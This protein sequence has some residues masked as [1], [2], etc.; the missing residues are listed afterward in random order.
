MANLLAITKNKFFNLVLNAL[1]TLSSI[2]HAYP[3]YILYLLFFTPCIL[4]ILSFLSPLFITTSLLIISLFTAISPGFVKDTLFGTHSSNVKAN[5]LLSAYDAVSKI[6][7]H[8][9][10]DEEEDFHSLEALEMYKIVFNTSIIDERGNHVDVS[11][12]YPQEKILQTVESSVVKILEDD[13][14]ECSVKTEEVLKV[15]T[16]LEQGSSIDDTQLKNIKSVIKKFEGFLKKQEES[17]FKA[18][19]EEIKTVQIEINQNRTFGEKNAEQLVEVVQ[20]DNSRRHSISKSKNSQSMR[21]CTTTNNN[22]TETNIELTSNDDVFRQTGRDLGRYGS[23]RKEREWRSTL[24]C[25]L[26]EEKHNSS[27]IEGIEG[28][29]SLWEKYDELEPMNPN[30]KKETKKME[31]SKSKKGKYEYGQDDEEEDDDFGGHLCCLHA[32]KLSTSKMNLGVGRRNLAKISKAV[33][34]FGWMHKTSKHSKKVHNNNGE[35][36]QFA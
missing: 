30:T 29:D 3:L 25:K 36:L 17:V 7:Q 32:F 2:L 18:C 22:K 33:K 8:N 13:E 15:D 11:E 19:N 24:A 9:T 26:F 34:G 16:N 28:M 21:Q 6:L 35:A 20:Y 14:Q 23:M 4:K 10:N 31:S 12:E 27:N 1:I 5:Y